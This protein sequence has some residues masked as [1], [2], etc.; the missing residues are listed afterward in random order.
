M[1]PWTVQDWDAL[2]ALTGLTKKQLILAFYGQ[3]HG[4]SPASLTTNL[5]K[6]LLTLVTQDLGLQPNQA[7]EEKMKTK[8]IKIEKGTAWKDIPPYELNSYKEAAETAVLTRF[9]RDNVT[10]WAEFAALHK[11]LG[12]NTGTIEYWMKVPDGP[13]IN[14]LGEVAP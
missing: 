11:Y 5:Q 13:E 9:N 4:M 10:T 3:I 8:V 6:R 14:E 2:C 12:P 1:R 7:P